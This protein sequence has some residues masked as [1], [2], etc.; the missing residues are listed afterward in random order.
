MIL[1]FYFIFEGLYFV[2]EGLELSR[3]CFEKAEC[4]VGFLIDAGDQL[5]LI[6]VGV[7]P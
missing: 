2:F 7:W 6:G 1:K 5:A 4:D 3:F